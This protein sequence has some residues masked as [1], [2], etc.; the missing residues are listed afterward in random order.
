MYGDLQFTNNANGNKWKGKTKVFKFKAH[1]LTY[2]EC[3]FIMGFCG[4]AADLAEVATF[5]DY[6]ELHKRPPKGRNLSGLVL[7]ANREI[8]V[9]D[10]YSTWLRVNQPF[11]AVGTGSTYAIGAMAMGASPKEAVRAAMKHDI[12]TGYG[13]KG[14]ALG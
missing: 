14:Y 9:F 13:T 7:T 2:P 4:S 6:P 11:L 12:Y 8:F 10:H 1:E 3:D 5:Y